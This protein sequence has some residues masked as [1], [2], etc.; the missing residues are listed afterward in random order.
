MTHDS[1][2][3]TRCH[4]EFSVLGHGSFVFGHRFLAALCY[5]SGTRSH[6]KIDPVVGFGSIVRRTYSV[7]PS[8]PSTTIRVTFSAT[9]VEGCSAWA[10]AFSG[11][12]EN[13]LSTLNRCESPSRMSTGSC[14]L[15]TSP[16]P[17]DS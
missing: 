11:L 10:S 1:P 15:Y 14:L 2:C 8:L 12:A 6:E 5:C 17:R 4:G 13:G 3:I 7:R 16:S 9:G